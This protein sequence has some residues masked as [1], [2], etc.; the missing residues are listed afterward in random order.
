MQ[1]GFFFFFYSVLQEINWVGGG[2]RHLQDISSATNTCLPSKTPIWTKD[3]TV[4][5]SLLFA[6]QNNKL[7]SENKYDCSSNSLTT[8]L[9]CLARSSVKTVWTNLLILS[10]SWLQSLHTFCSLAELQD[11]KHHLVGILELVGTRRVEISSWTLKR[12]SICT[13]FSA[14]LFKIK[15]VYTNEN[16]QFSVLKGGYSQSQLEVKKKKKDNFHTLVLKIEDVMA[17]NQLQTVI[18]AVLI[19]LDN[20]FK[21]KRIKPSQGV[22]GPITFE[23]KAFITKQN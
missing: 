5:S 9:A 6:L 11:S 22:A 17:V 2:E 10:G 14:N 4:S 18:L 23:G 15:K 1:D 16:T 21:D 3:T 7:A 13:N 12:M 8:T 20:W 19:S